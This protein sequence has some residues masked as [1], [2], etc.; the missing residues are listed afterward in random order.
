VRATGVRLGLAA[1][2]ALLS[3]VT[4]VRA[5]DS[6]VVIDPNAPD[7]AQHGG[8]PPD[9][10]HE[11]LAAYNDSTAVRLTGDVNVPPDGKL[12]GRVAVYHGTVDVAGQ[13]DGSLTIINGD[14]RV[15]STG[16]ITG[17]VL[18][19]GG[20]LTADVGS[21]L[22]SGSR[23]FWDAAPV[24]RRSN[25]QL[26]VREPGKT[27]AELASAQASFQTGKVRT[28]LLLATNATYNR[29]EGLPIIF[30]PAFDWKVSPTV[31]ARLELRGIVRT[32]GWDAPL[33]RPFGYSVR[34]D[35]GFKGPTGYGFG[36][37]AY[38]QVNG[39]EEQTQG[40]E[41]VGWW[42]ILSQNDNRDY[43][44]A[45]GIAGSAFAY[46]AKPLRFDLS[47]RWQKERTLRANDPWS[48]FTTES[49]WRPNPLID[50]G[51]Y[52]ILGLGLDLDTRNHRKRPTSGWLVHLGYEYATSDNVSPA[53][54]PP[55][56]R[57]PI[58]TRNYG[59]GCL[60]LDARRYNRLS[61]DIRLNFRLWAGG[62]VGGDPLPV[63][64]R[65][66]LG[67]VDWLAGYPFRAFTCAPAGSNDAAEPALCDRTIVLQAELRRRFRLGLGF[68]FKDEARPD[69]NRFLGID[70]ADLV[71]FADGGNTWLTGDGPGRVPNDRIPNLGEWKGDLGIGLDAGGIGAYILKALTGS[72]PVRVMVRLQRRF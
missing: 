14:L 47:Y 45:E 20:R 26:V 54:L 13:I 66:S 38:S 69:L 39:I 25:G 53:T 22:E 60:V 11:L 5:Q 58:P 8:L 62:W 17:P 63:Q 49:G 70:E 72:E 3:L 61:P 4:T 57:S 19:A 65:L 10:L 34:T 24:Y 50:D 64:R 56:V 21:Q 68:Q 1:V 18:V 23:V 51:E 67:G 27:P 2:G 7:T 31:A 12:A 52:W 35:W 29:V 33:G 48:L 37:R 6:V 59:Y 42:A 43:Y 40:R 30:G 32:S 55:E 41:E 16:R 46:L 15:R 36:L 9:V 44:N 71:L 28:T